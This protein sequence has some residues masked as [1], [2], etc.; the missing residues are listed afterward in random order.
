[1]KERFLIVT[2]DNE[3]KKFYN[4]IVY[5]FDIDAGRDRCF[6]IDLYGRTIVN[7]IKL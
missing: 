3:T 1:M 2:Y 7:I 4:N 6:D 5:N